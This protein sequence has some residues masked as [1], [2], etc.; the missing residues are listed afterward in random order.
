MV[1]TFEP[2]KTS[3]WMA[4]LDAAGLREAWGLDFLQESFNASGM[5]HV[6]HMAQVGVLREK[7]FYF[8]VHVDMCVFWCV[9]FLVHFF[10]SVSM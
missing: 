1:N 2:Q 8:T 3:E 6:Q 4:S 10:L 7:G 9:C 5:F